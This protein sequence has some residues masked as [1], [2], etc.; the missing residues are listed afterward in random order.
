MSHW[1]LALALFLSAGIIAFYAVQVPLEGRSDLASKPSLLEDP[2]VQRRSNQHLFMTAKELEIAALKRQYENQL[3]APYVGQKLIDLTF[4]P[5]KGVDHSADRNEETA[6]KDLQ[7]DQHDLNLT[8]P[9]HIVQSQLR[10]NE[11]LAAYSESY[12][13]AYA[14][15]F[16]EN[17]RRAGYEVRLSADLV[18]LSVRKIK[19]MPK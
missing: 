8:S 3:Q 10:E 9:Q 17:A 12:R 5:P 13:Q 7:R 6:Y 11:E 14:S 4:A 1:T 2:I 18:V 19:S 15:Q 16:V